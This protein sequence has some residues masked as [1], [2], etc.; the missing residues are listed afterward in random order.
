VISCESGVVTEKIKPVPDS[1]WKISD[2][3]S[4]E[5]LIAD[6]SK[7]YNFILII[8]HTTDYAYR[9]LF[10]FTE[11]L[12]PDSTMANDTIEIILADKKGQWYGKGSGYIK[13]LETTLIPKAQFIQEGKYQFR[14]NQG[15][16]EDTLKHIKNIGIRI[17]SIEK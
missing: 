15:M 10:F 3:L 8:R 16:R 13:T 4:F 12:L 7:R 2:T 14:F 17:E 5:A 6:S 11:T 1:G 9:N